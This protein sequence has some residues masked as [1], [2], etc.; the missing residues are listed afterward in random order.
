[1][2][3]RPLRLTVLQA[4]KLSVFTQTHGVSVFLCLSS[5]TKE[6]PIWPI[7]MVVRTM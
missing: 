5:T 7:Q 3:R 4:V 6:T 2:V 1:M